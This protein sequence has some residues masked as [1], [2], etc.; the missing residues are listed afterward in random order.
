[1]KILGK[2]TAYQ[3]KRNKIVLDKNSRNTL[4]SFNEALFYELLSKPN[5][6]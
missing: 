6:L 5:I 1:M 4:F 3:G 2:N